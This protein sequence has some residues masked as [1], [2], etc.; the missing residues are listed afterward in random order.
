MIAEGELEIRLAGH[1]VEKRNADL[2]RMYE[3]YHEIGS[4]VPVQ[5]MMEVV[6]KDTL[7]EDGPVNYERLTE[8]SYIKD[9]IEDLRYLRTG[10]DRDLSFDL[11]EEDEGHTQKIETFDYAREYQNISY[12]P[13]MHGN[14]SSVVVFPSREGIPD[15]VASFIAK[16]AQNYDATR[17]KEEAEEVARSSLAESNL[18]R[19]YRVSLIACDPGEHSS[20][21]VQALDFYGEHDYWGFVAAVTRAVVR[22]K[23]EGAV[24]WSGNCHVDLDHSGRHGNGNGDEYAT[25]A[26]ASGLGA[27]FGQGP[28][29][30]KVVVNAASIV[31]SEG[32]KQVFELTHSRLKALA[33]SSDWAHAKD[34]VMNVELGAGAY[35]SDM[36]VRL[37]NTSL[38]PVE[39]SYYYHTEMKPQRYQDTAAAAAGGHAQTGGGQQGNGKRAGTGH[40]LPVQKV[41]LPVQFEEVV[42]G[43]TAGGLTSVALVKSSSTSSASSS[44]GGG[45]GGG[46]KSS[47]V[48]IDTIP[49]VHMTYYHQNRPA[50]RSSGSNS[51]SSP[52]VQSNQEQEQEQGGGNDNPPGGNNNPQQ[53]QEQK[54]KQEQEQEEGAVVKPVVNNSVSQQVRL[55]AAA[56]F[57]HTE[58]VLELHLIGA[59][60]LL[61]NSPRPPS[62]YCACY[63]I[64]HDGN[65]VGNGAGGVGDRLGMMLGRGA[66]NQDGEWKT[67]PVDSSHNPEWATTILIQ[68]PPPPSSIIGDSPNSHNKNSCSTEGISHVLV[69]FKDVVSK[70]R[71]PVHIGQVMVPLGCFIEGQAVPLTLP[72][73]HTP[74]MPDS[75]LAAPVTGM[76]H[77]EVRTV[78]VMEGAG[79]TYSALLIFLLSLFMSVSLSYLSLHSLPPHDTC[80]TIIPIPQSIIHTILT[81][82]IIA[83]AVLGPPPESAHTRVKSI[84]R[85][86][87]SS[88]SSSSSSSVETVTV[89]YCLKPAASDA[90]AVFWPFKVLGGSLGRA[91]GHVACRRSGLVIDL[92]PGSGGVLATCVEVTDTNARVG[93]AQARVAARQRADSTPSQNNNK[94]IFSVEWENVSRVLAVTDSC[95][96]LTVAV[97]R[98][99]ESSS[100]SSSGSGSKSNN[101]RNGQTAAAPRRIQMAMQEILLAPCPA[102]ALQ[103]G[104][105]ERQN[106]LPIRREMRRFQAI[107]SDKFSSAAGVGTGGGTA[108][109]AMIGVA[110]SH[111][112]TA[113]AA[114]QADVVRAGRQFAREL[115][116]MLAM[117]QKMFRELLEQGNRDG[118]NENEEGVVVV[119]EKPQAHSAAGNR[120][121]G[122]WGG[123]EH[124]SV[125]RD[126]LNR[127]AQA[128]EATRAL[129]QRCMSP[130]S[131]GGYEHCLV[132]ARLR[133]RASLYRVQLTELCK[134]LASSEG[135]L[136]RSGSVIS[137]AAAAA[138]AVSAVGTPS[139]TTPGDINY[140]HPDG[141]SNSNS[142][143]TPLSSHRGARTA[144]TLPEFTV[145]GVKAAV[146]VALQGVEAQVQES[147]SGLAEEL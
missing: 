124:Q 119:L 139:A 120:K 128:A 108:S 123:G 17:N 24:N 38:D 14:K 145:D 52:V 34:Y 75:M 116:E 22:N 61:A 93:Q 62:A 47:A 94:L 144:V 122:R 15:R 37:L 28:K 98:E 101:N 97:H 44:S 117:E 70:F 135:A 8:R 3:D 71:K 133:I 110:H 136:I 138:A 83:G 129:L 73:E 89:N 21:K 77:M 58:K 142:N 41:L 88:S 91:E 125:D 143:S 95:L 79:G 113:T 65:R 99:V 69:V 12:Y 31:L 6:I 74:K 100:S 36:R 81:L 102:R 5:K 85:A 92:A 78:E 23:S 50:A 10:K 67:D 29:A 147:A 90:L 32:S 49:F 86:R 60:D 84:F 43:A 141:N 51:S 46:G 30:Q 132:S 121:G 57:A 35:P 80:L 33:L 140:H 109:G 118:N 105:A 137:A 20:P 82:L 56:A 106:S 104:I 72:L 19:H 16:I 26:S 126:R 4:S 114:A 27:L 11:D 40:N 68:Q 59:E 64:D 18:T 63:L 2:S 87:P 9:L 25:A 7:D 48:A 42:A 39:R 130:G 107:A 54:Q 115:G 146:A 96:V 131:M 103:L 127:Q 111:S 134:G 112:A 1:R 45:G 13:R 53:E 55:G 76:V 66:S